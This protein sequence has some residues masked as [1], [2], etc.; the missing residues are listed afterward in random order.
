MEMI[1]RHSQYLSRLLDVLVCSL[2][3]YFIAADKCVGFGVR[4]GKGRR[5]P[6]RQP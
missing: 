5:G 3:L 4:H 2:W 1:T 6:Q